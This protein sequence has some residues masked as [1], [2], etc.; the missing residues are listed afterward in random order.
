MGFTRD[1]T[2][3]ISNLSY[4]GFVSSLG[5]DDKII[6]G[7][8]G[9]CFFS[10]VVV[11]VLCNP[12]EMFKQNI[13]EGK[14][15]LTV[16]QYYKTA[17]ENYQQIELTPK[18]S[19]VAYILDGLES[20]IKGKSY[21][22]YPFFSNHFSLPVKPGEHVWILGEANRGKIVYYWMTRKSCPYQIEDSNYS[23]L[24]RYMKDSKLYNLSKKVQQKDATNRLYHFHENKISPLYP[25]D[26]QLLDIVDDA[27]AN[28]NDFTSEP[29]PTIY[30]KPGDTLI[31]G[32]NNSYIHF[33][34]EKFTNKETC[35]TLYGENFFVNKK[36]RLLG[37][38]GNEKN[39]IPFSPAIDISIAAFKKD[40]LELHEQASS[41]GFSKDIYE[42]DNLSIAK[43][44]RG[45][46][47]IN[48]SIDNI[49][50]AKHESSALM[51]N[52]TALNCGSRLYMSNNCT[53]D[54]IF[55]INITNFQKQHGSSIV[56]YSEHNRMFATNTLLIA[57]NFNE[58]NASYLSI[59]KEGIIQ[60]GSKKGNK[61][62]EGKTSGLQP[63]VRGDDLET[64]LKSLITELNTV[65]NTIGTAMQSSLSPFFSIPI[66][67]LTTNASSV[68]SS[69]SSINNLAQEL[70]KFKS[71]LIKGE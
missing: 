52:Y 53:I 62:S 18:N 59:D 69:A 71:T 45:A 39:R 6:E 23:I 9:Y 43:N 3:D 47:E 5:D 27:Y 50:S 57:N 41:D 30:K 60:L 15:S 46:Y 51:S 11:D 10:G 65:L 21:L 7:A 44:T 26:A 61:E 31:Q 34:T 33:T 35:N 55:N 58:E 20:K 54:D 25:N 16:K 19:I 29:V 38:D 14:E 37:K 2:G 22:C 28:K 4:T 67:S 66:P 40:I 1:K 13:D 70:P 63:F 49:E 32:S 42:N 68:L 24:E 36:N 48:K 64:V 8:T 56:S 12:K 17:I